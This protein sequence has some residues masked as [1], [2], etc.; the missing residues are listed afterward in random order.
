MSHELELPSGLNEGSK[1]RAGMQDNPSHFERPR[2]TDVRARSHY[3]N[4]LPERVMPGRWFRFK[5]LEGE[6][7]LS[8]GG[9]DRATMGFVTHKVEN[10]L[11]EPDR[12]TYFFWNGGPL[13]PAT[14]WSDL[15]LGPVI[16][17]HKNYQG[18]DSVSFEANENSPVLWGDIVSVDP[19]GTGVGRAL[20][21]QDPMHYYGVQRDVDAARAFV[22]WYITEFKR[23]K[24]PIILVGA[25]YAAFRV[26]GVAHELHKR[27][28]TVSALAFISGHYDYALQ[29]YETDN[30]KPFTTILPVMALAAQAHKRLNTREQHMPPDILYDEVEQFAN[31]SYLTALSDVSRLTLDQRKS[32]V[33]NLAAYTGLSQSFIDELNLRINPTIFRKQLLEEKG[34]EISAA[35][36]RLAFPR[37]H[38]TRIDPALDLWE[39]AYREAMV[40]QSDI[41]PYAR[42]DY[43]GIVNAY[44]N[45][46]F[47]GIWSKKRVH[48]AMVALLT[49]CPELQILHTAGIYDF[50][51]P[52]ARAEKFWKSI[53]DQ[54]GIDVRSTQAVGT[55]LGYRE[56]HGVDIVRFLA[57][58]QIGKDHPTNFMLGIA[59]RSL[60][61]AQ[62]LRASKLDNK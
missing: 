28:I 13:T 57:G 61:R 4:K 16:I 10:A 59:L 33:E 30:P 38:D 11:T 46:D 15:T 37:R 39:K 23:E 31:G 41:F 7:M 42:R 35:D 20:P 25:S 49:D 36:S 60:S 1:N 56:T 53:S 24:S 17:R 52:P 34:L 58:H 51:N 9:K 55:V 2:L 14:M 43:Q 3:I 44:P 8:D 48:E 45:W 47:S 54:T 12:P 18:L 26:T 21:G 6:V 62:K 40:N 29:D 22:E 27:G 50:I 5:T 32:I 19:V